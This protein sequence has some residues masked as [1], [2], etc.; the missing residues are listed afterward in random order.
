MNDEQEREARWLVNG[1]RYLVEHPEESEKWL[2]PWLD[3][4]STYAYTYGMDEQ[5]EA[6]ARELDDWTARRLAAYQQR[7][8]DGDGAVPDQPTRSDP[9][10]GALA[11][12]KWP[13]T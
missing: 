10:V 3:R 1:W 4:L 2:D 6:V 13:G 12:P 5:L 11:R 7:N 9:P 8:P